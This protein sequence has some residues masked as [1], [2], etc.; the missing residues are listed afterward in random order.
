MSMVTTEQIKELR[1]MT[2]VSVIQCK[3]A[4]EEANGDKEKAL[5]ILRKKS[6]DIAAKKGDRVFGAGSV[7][8]Y[9]HSN[10]TVGALVELV[11]ETDFVAN[12]Q[13][14]KALAREI[15]MHVAAS[16]PSYVRTSEIPE[17][18][19]TKAKELFAGEVEGKPEELK[20]KI[21]SGK[22][23][24]YFKERVLLEQPYIKNPDV[25]VSGLIEQAIQKFGEK[26]DVGR[27]ARFDVLG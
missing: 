16:N 15:A 25:T 9:I 8:S 24:S 13:E 14:F 19:Q 22:I 7:A 3:K 23:G 6:K 12:N 21:L 2:G 17:S 26:I 5:D 11:T 20:E 10:G 4:L 27:I 1:D 18:E